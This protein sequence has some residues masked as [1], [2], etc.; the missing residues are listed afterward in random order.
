MAAKSIGSEKPVLRGRSPKPQPPFC[1]RG[2]GV[3]EAK[4]FHQSISPLC[5][6]L[7][8]TKVQEMKVSGLESQTA[9]PNSCGCDIVAEEGV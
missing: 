2:E 1:G 7:L 9:P 8:L 6:P 4:S 5:C 3:V